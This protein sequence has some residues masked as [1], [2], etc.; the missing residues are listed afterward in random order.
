[1]S[2]KMSFEIQGLNE[3]NK[4]LSNLEK[5]IK[6]DVITPAVKTA[7]KKAVKIAKR[8]VPVL[9]GELKRH[10]VWRMNRQKK[11]II[12][13]VIFVKRD[14]ILSK[15]ELKKGGNFKFNKKGKA[16]KSVYY[17]HF[18]EYGSIHNIPKPFIRPA[19]KEANP[20][21]EVQDA[22]NKALREF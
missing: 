5:N 13:A 1:M 10:I 2:D 19:L 21:E 6:K 15:R 3:L 16:I 22:I 18:V 17:A 14:R 11:G 4:K 9:T 7:M 20:Q 12:S 8:K